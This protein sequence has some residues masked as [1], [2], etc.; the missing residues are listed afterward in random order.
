MKANND[1]KW[2]PHSAPSLLSVIQ[3]TYNQLNVG[4]TTWKSLL[5]SSTLQE[6]CNKGFNVKAGNINVRLGV[7]SNNEADC[8]SPYSWLGF[9]TELIGTTLCGGPLS[10]L[11]G[12]VDTCENVD[13]KAF[14]MIFV[15]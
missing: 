7:I 11:C 15:K 5:T 8:I 12:N 1:V 9:G 13:M 6:N 10:T 2:I 3:P 4:S 14:G